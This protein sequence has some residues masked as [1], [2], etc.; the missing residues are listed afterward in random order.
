MLLSLKTSNERKSKSE[1]EAGGLGWLRIQQK[2]KKKKE[3]PPL[4]RRVHLYFSICN[5]VIDMIRGLGHLEWSRVYLEIVEHFVSCKR[6]SIQS[7]N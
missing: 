6:Q 2:K 1:E 7:D 5:R 3:L 4:F